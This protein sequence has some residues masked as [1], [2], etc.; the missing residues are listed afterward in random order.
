MGW[1]KVL[2]GLLDMP[3]CSCSSYRHHAQKSKA[4]GFCYV[5][6]CVLAILLLRKSTP[7]C[8]VLYLD[9]DLHYSDAVSAA[10]ASTSN[11]LTISIHHRAP[12]FFP[13]S[14]VLDKND[15]YN[16]CIPLAAGAS[17]DTFR[18]IWSR[19]ETIKKA[20]RPDF[21]VVQCGLDGLAED[22]YKIWNWSLDDGEG[23]LGW[24]IHRLVNEWDSKTLFLG[25]GG[26]NTPNAARAWS[27]LT[28]IIVSRCSQIQGSLY[29][30]APAPAQRADV[31]FV[32][33]P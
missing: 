33:D 7:G 27:F 25:G 4:S 15:P 16:I 10:F 1:W 17:D 5:N 13:P 29:L 21:V 28:S 18:L 24:C 9:L 30:I 19:I 31:E 32:R 20:F 8:R 6:D 3:P 12:G 11:V 22:P 2:S 23:S 26:Y 14:P